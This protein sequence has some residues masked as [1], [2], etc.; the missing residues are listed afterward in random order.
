M[1][2][3]FS[4]QDPY[5][6]IVMTE[7]HPPFLIYGDPSSFKADFDPSM[8]I[9]YTIKTNPLD[10]SPPHVIRLDSETSSFMRSHVSGYG[11]GCGCKCGHGGW[12]NSYVSS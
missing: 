10:A 12:E 9:I 8:T 7:A 4:P 11:C 1:S 2:Q 6:D 3:H 5:D